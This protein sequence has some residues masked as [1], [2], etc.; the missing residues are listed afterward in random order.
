[1]EILWHWEDGGKTP[2][3]VCM[4]L[5]RSP[6]PC[7]I[8][9]S[10]ALAISKFKGCIWILLPST[11]VLWLPFVKI[12]PSRNLNI[13][14]N[15]TFKGTIMWIVFTLPLYCIHTSLCPKHLSFI[16]YVLKKIKE[17]DYNLWY[18]I[19]EETEIEKHTS[20]ILIVL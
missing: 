14:K 16:F 1:M 4:P 13:N 2:L 18:A 7:F 15:L 3:F 8:F 9:S 20:H 11:D 12:F 6:W 17:V 10:Q 19:D 5:R